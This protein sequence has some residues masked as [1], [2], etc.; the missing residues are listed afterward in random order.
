MKEYD[1]VKLTVEKE[2]YTIDGAHKGMVGWICDPRN[3]NGQWLVCFDEC[4]LPQF[5]TIPV[6]EKD[7]EVVWESHERQV[8]DKMILLAETYTGQ[9]FGKGLKGVLSE[10]LPNNKWLV[11]FKKQDGLTVDSDLVVNG[12][13]F[14]LE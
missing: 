13:D 11:R 7:L 12:N 10:K 5:P 9:G 6:N 4:D 14:I 1:R 3:I 8:G 2:K